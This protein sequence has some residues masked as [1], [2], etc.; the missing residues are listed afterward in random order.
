MQQAMHTTRTASSLITNVSKNVLRLICIVSDDV[1][2]FHEFWDPG[3]NN[4]QLRASST[5]L[6]RIKVIIKNDRNS[7]CVLRYPVERVEEILIWE[8]TIK[9]I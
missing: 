1:L 2:I 3:R 9:A 6:S 4:F 7:A 5:K 8:T